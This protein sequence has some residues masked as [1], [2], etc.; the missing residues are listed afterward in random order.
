MVQCIPFSI[1]YRR[2]YSRGQRCKFRKH[3]HALMERK[4]CF[5]DLNRFDQKSQSSTAIRE[6]LS[7]GRRLST[8]DLLVL[9]GLDHLL[10]LM[11]IVFTF[12]YKIRYLNEE[13]NRIESSLWL[14]FPAAITLVPSNP[15]SSLLPPR[16]R[17]L[18]R[19]HHHMFI[20]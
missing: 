13:V 1:P 19:I 18:C 17:P 7:K 4:K 2:V 11:K 14:A 5:L 6:T 8:V 10:F 3:K 15:P 20:C 16:P 12:L 9:T